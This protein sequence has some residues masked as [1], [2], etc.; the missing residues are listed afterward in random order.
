LHIYE[1]QVINCKGLRKT[2]GFLFFAELPTASRGGV[3]GRKA[4]QNQLYAEFQD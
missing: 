2:E 1:K 3:A 4:A